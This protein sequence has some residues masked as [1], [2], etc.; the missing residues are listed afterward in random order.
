MIGGIILTHGEFGAGIKNA[1][2]GMM[3][4]QKGLIV[5][6]NTGLSKEKLKESLEEAIGNHEFKDGGFVF[7]D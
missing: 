6:T 2:E 3:G 7:V 4:E 1:L 5:L